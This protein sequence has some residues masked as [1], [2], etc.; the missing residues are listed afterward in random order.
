M[1]TRSCDGV[2]VIDIIGD[3]YLK[4]GD[5]IRGFYKGYLMTL[6][7][8]L[9]FNSIIWTLYWKIQYQLE[10]IIPSK[11]EKII[12]P[13]SSTIAAL[14]TSFITQPIDVLKTRL[15]VSSKQQSIFKIARILVQQRGFKG[16]FSGS[17]PRAL[18]VLPNSV[19]MMSL[20]EIIKRASVK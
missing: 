6:G 16:F 19:I 20:Y 17:V 15:Q 14:L 18:I 2:R 3:I 11:Y 1:I 5:G 4:S 8:S 9:P 12:A 13:S 7:I 10:R